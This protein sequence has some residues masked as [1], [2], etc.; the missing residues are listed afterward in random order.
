MTFSLKFH[1]RSNYR[2]I[3]I[4]TI[5]DLAPMGQE[6]ITRTNYDNIPRHKLDLMD[7]KWLR[8]QLE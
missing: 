7:H 8:Q 3:I 2:Y 1:T 6:A 4:G 5:D